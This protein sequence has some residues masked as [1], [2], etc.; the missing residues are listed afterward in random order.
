MATQHKQIYLKLS[1]IVLFIWGLEAAV[2]TRSQIPDHHDP[3]K[4]T[5]IVYISISVALSSFDAARHAT[6]VDQSF[7]RSISI[8]QYTRRNCGNHIPIYSRN[9]KER[10]LPVPTINCS[11]SSNQTAPQP[12]VKPQTTS[13]CCA[14]TVTKEHLLCSRY[15]CSCSEI[16][17]RLIS[18]IPSLMNRRGN[19]LHTVDDNTIWYRYVTSR[20]SS[21]T[22]TPGQQLPYRCWCHFHSDVLSQKCIGSCYF[23]HSPWTNEPSDT[24]HYHR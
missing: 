11:A 19:N 12:A 24:R 15:D 7:L 16:R 6:P 5:K 22:S 14:V 4:G 17:F 18:P 9:L 3:N 13:T 23:K 20:R 2:P 8:S 10:F 21:S 1:R